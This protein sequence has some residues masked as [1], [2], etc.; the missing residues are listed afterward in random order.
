MNRL[1][2]LAVACMLVPTLAHA[3]NNTSTLPA[4]TFIVDTAYYDTRTRIRWDDTRTARPLLDGIDRYEPGGG[5]QGTITANPL[6]KYQL[7]VPQ[8]QYGLTDDLTLVL[9]MPT[10]IKSAIQPR[11]GWIP[12]DYQNNLGRSYTEDDFWQWAKSM[13]QNKPGDWQGNE[14]KLADMV[15]GGR[16]S[17]SHLNFFHEH[18]LNAAVSAQVA[19]PTGSN[20]DPE[21]LVAAGT[22]VWDLHNYGDFEVHF[23]LE[24]PWKWEEFT[25][26]NFGVDLYYGWMRERTFTTS[27]GINSPLLMTFAPYV[28]ATYKI[29]PGD[30]IGGTV[31]VEGV[32]FVG[33]TLSTWMNQH[34]PEKSKKWPGLLTLTAAVTYAHLNQTTWSSQSALWNWDHEKLWLPGDKNTIKFNADLS[35]MRLGLPLMLYAGYRTQEWIPGRNSRATD[36]LM[37]GGRI[38]LKFW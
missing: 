25:R 29:D 12:G 9:A 17:L 14:W 23:A 22:T 28:G 18:E 6:V 26:I 11:L 4:N 2:A 24:K 5:L 1:R 21:E 16:Y 37:L 36:V 20:P 33:P 35:L 30:M 34:D 32:P 8:L 13:G 31:L 38:I 15:V 3:G 10:V 7:F 19:L 27:T